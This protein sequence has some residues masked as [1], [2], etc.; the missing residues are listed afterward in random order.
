MTVEIKK[1]RKGQNEVFVLRFSSSPVFRRWT[2]D[3]GFVPEL[4]GKPWDLVPFCARG[5]C[6]V[7][8]CCSEWRYA[9]RTGKGPECLG[10]VVVCELA[11]WFRTRTAFRRMD[12]AAFYLENG[13]A[14]VKIGNTLERNP[15][16]F[17]QWTLCPGH[18]YNWEDASSSSTTNGL[19]ISPSSS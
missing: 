5:R 19:L 2:T 4:A 3:C 14:L 9:S 8:R 18:S 6:D 10:A 17:A 7:W 15:S 12:I 11:G 1:L 16:W 13:K